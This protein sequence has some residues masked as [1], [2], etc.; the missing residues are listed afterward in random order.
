M[1]CRFQGRADTR[2]N[3]N[4]FS[5]D[6]KTDSISRLGLLFCAFVLVFSNSKFPSGFLEFYYCHIPY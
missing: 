5:W 1:M 2:H 4:L 3:E 6:S